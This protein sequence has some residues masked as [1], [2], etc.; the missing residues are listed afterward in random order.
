M[1]K[2]YLIV[3]LIALMLLAFCISG[4]LCQDVQCTI[5]TVV[6][7]DRVFFGNNEDWHAKDLIIGFYP[8]SSEGFGSVN[9]G[10]MDGNGNYQ[11]EGVV[12]ERGLAWD[13]NSIPKMR[14]KEDAEKDFHVYEDNFFYQLSKKIETVDEAIEFSRNFSFGKKFESQI[15]VTDRYGN[16]VVIGPGENGE[17]AY[18]RKTQGDGYLVS[19]N[20]NLSTPEK[21]PRDFR[22]NLASEMLDDFSS[23][24]S[25]GY[26]G[27]ILEA[28]SLNTLSSFTLYSNVYDL[29]KGDIYIYYMSQYDQVVKL[30]IEEE[31]SKGKRVIPLKDLFP[32]EISKAGDDAYRRFS[33][34]SN[35][36]KWSLIALILIFMVIGI[37]GLN[38]RIKKWRTKASG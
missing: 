24:K 4:I 35:L 26:L 7:G 36:V 3:L 14:L 32:E 18:T 11:Y 38:K 13:V 37:L 21:G 30:N 23:E 6:E 28:V 33:L 19:T 2:R 15:H 12:N 17:M 29:G 25:S 8:E 31:L 10:H 5:F 20:F 1:K 9:F 27:K 16:A 34:K 22:Y